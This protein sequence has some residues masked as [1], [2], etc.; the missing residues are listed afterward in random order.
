MN[1]QNNLMDK[2]I[3]FESLSEY[4]AKRYPDREILFDKQL[5]VLQEFIVEL[6]IRGFRTIG[7]IHKTLERTK[8]AV[9]LFEMDFPPNIGLK[10][11]QYS[12]TG[13]ARISMLLLD[14]DFFT[15]RKTILNGSIPEKLEKYRKHILPE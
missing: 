14:N 2:E 15:F 13:I 10:G 5:G 11:S 9:E 1:M 12:A 8:K 6:N 4:L 7:E 3:D